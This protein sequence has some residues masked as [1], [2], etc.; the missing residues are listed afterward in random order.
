MNSYELESN[1]RPAIETQTYA[2][3]FDNIYFII[4]WQIVVPIL[5]RIGIGDVTAVDIEQSENSIGIQY[6]SRC[7]YEMCF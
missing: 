5:H 1:V 6:S 2:Q 4:G 3:T 7:R